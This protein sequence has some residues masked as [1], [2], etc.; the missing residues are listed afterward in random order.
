[1]NMI[2]S[3]LRTDTYWICDDCA[4][5]RNWEHYK[6]GNTVIAGYCGHCDRQDEVKLTPM[7]DFK[8]PKAAPYPDG[9]DYK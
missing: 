4:A 6:T 5:E 1:M 8:K 7:R 9:G 2:S 3:D